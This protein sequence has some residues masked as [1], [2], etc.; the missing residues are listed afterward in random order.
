MTPAAAV[1]AASRVTSAAGW[2]AAL[3][4]TAL[5]GLGAARERRGHGGR[6]RLDPPA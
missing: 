1:G 3:A 4:V 2:L 6:R 5:L